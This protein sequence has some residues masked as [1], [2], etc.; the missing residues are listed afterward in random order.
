[1]NSGSEP[2][3]EPQTVQSTCG[4]SSPTLKP[5]QAPESCRQAGKRTEAHLVGQDDVLPAVPCMAQ[6]VD[7][8]QLVP[9]QLP[10]GQER[11]RRREPPLALRPAAGAGASRG[12]VRLAP[13]ACLQTEPTAGSSFPETP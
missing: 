12:L 3:F 6:P 4:E 10:A 5:W 13:L 2:V 11:R 7:A 1:M 8:L 9:V